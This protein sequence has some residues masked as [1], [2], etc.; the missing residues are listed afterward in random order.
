MKKV[1]LIVNPIAG[2]MKILRDLADIDKAFYDGDCECDIYITKKKGDATSKVIR[3]GANYDMIACGGGDGT[4]NEVMTGVIKAG[5][6]TPIGYIP[7]GTTNDFAATL[8]LS[9]NSVTAVENIIKGRPRKLD[10][11]RFGDQYFSYIA[12]F[13]AFTSASYSTPQQ[14]KNMLGRSA[15]VFGGMQDLASLKPYHVRLEANGRVY[16]DDYA[17]GSISNSTSIAGLIKLNN[18]LVN[19]SDGEFEIILIK[20]PKLIIELPQ[21]LFALANGD[22]TE[23]HL[24]F[25]HAPKVKISTNGQLDWALDG[26]YA[27]SNGDIVLENVHRAVD[28]IF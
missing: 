28:L 9:P 15:Y 1:L 3:S 6:S 17:F 5:L 10:V 26:E 22:Y 14:T 11:G 21:I 2:K 25:I 7:S 23:E 19:L 13:G 20:M 4:Y 18:K 12:S 8:E 27:S 24:I 16:E